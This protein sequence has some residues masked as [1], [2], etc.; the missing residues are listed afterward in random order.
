MP[1]TGPKKHTYYVLGQKPQA[2]ARGYNKLF[3]LM[4][5]G[6]EVYTLEPFAQKSNICLL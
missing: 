6:F 1:T 2:I 5:V 4:F 3:Q